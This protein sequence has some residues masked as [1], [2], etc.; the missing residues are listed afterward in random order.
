MI[1]K[2]IFE[3]HV[4]LNQDELEILETLSRKTGLTESELLRSCLTNIVFKE[5]PPK[6]FYD[7]LNK[8]N[9]IGININQIAHIANSTGE[10]YYDTLKLYF[11][12]IEQFMKEIK[13]KY[14]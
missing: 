11:S 10:I 3:K 1:R 12:Q 2:R 8:I 7:L 14:L 13:E 9:N 5:A 6:E 4:R